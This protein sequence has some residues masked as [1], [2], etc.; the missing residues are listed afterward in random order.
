MKTYV[1]K[2][3]YPSLPDNW[4]AGMLV[5]QGDRGSFSSFSPVSTLYTDYH[6]RRE[7]V[8]NNPE[9]WEEF[10]Q[11]SYQIL[12]ILN[13]QR[14]VD[15]IVTDKE[16]IKAYLQLLSLHK[17]SPW[18][19]N[20]VKRLFDGKVF[21]VGDVVIRHKDKNCPSPSTTHRT[22]SSFYIGKERDIRFKAGDGET[23]FFLELFSHITKGE[24]IEKYQILAFK[25]NKKGFFNRIWRADSQIKDSFCLNAGESPFHSSSSLINLGL[26]IYSIKRLSDNEIFTIGDLINRNGKS[27]KLEIIELDDFWMGGVAVNRKGSPFGGECLETLQK[28]RIPIFTTEDGIDIFEDSNYYCHINL[29][30][31]EIKESKIITKGVS[32]NLNPELFKY[33]STKEAAEDYIL[34]NKPCL[35]AQDVIDYTESKEG[36]LEGID[37]DFIELV[38]RKQ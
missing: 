4:E 29:K 12:S 27:V 24:L 25:E 6:V 38:K 21:T 23:G 5:G 7:D 20:S 9:Y 8:V 14:N 32:G 16:E 17:Q 36:P 28:A 13:P 31:F 35:S 22:I 2:Q 26:D 34:M 30:S 10:T 33:F 18:V 37:P 15:S 19:I 11:G 3:K 1:L